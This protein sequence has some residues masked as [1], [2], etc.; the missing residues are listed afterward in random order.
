MIL[1]STGIWIASSI[2]PSNF[3]SS[4]NGDLLST[5]EIKTPISISLKPSSETKEPKMYAK[6]IYSFA[7][8]I[9][10]IFSARTSFA[11]YFKFL[12]NFKILKN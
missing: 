4:F 11:Y 5:P 1:I 12:L 7:L 10:E 8:R 6:R 2:S 3:N 9:S